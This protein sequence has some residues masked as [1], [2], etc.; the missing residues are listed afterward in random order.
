MNME[1]AA[2]VT[3]TFRKF[4]MTS[5]S[6]G[7][8]ISVMTCVPQTAPGSSPKGVV[9]LV[10]GMCEH[11]ERY[12][13]FMNFWRGTDMPASSTT[14]VAMENL[15]VPGKISAISMKAASWP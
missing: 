14:T 11:K 7:L 4:G 2:N 10:H 12:I 9:Q 1:T 13:P 5:L 3:P 8:E 6:D 15:S